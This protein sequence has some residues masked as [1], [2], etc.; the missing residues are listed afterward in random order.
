[1]IFARLFAF[2]RAQRLHPIVFLG[3]IDQIEVHGKCRRHG[4][5]LVGRQRGDLLRQ[6]AC[7][8]RFIGAPSLCQSADAFF[9]FEQ[10]RRFLLTQHFAQQPAQQV[11]GGGEIHHVSPPFTAIATAPARLLTC[12]FCKM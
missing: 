6:P 8:F 4:A 7:G 1:M 9:D 3:Q 10:R 12:N 11:D 2:A 5:G